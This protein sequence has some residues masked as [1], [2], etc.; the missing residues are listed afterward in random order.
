[1]E[2]KSQTAFEMHAIR[3]GSPQPTTSAEQL[4]R[5]AAI[6][7]AALTL[8]GCYRTG[9]AH[10]PQVYVTAVVAVLSDYPLDIVTAVTNP[11][12]GIPAK[13]KWLPTI[14]E[15]KTACEDI[16]GPRRRI[17]EWE[18][19]SRA[20]LAERERLTTPDDDAERSRVINGFGQLRAQLQ[21]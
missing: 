9:D 15:I 4:K 16:A 18:A 19:R 12:V 14:A 11:S 5:S 8:L 13:L 21:G 20:Q 10:D 2:E 6:K 7:N 3:Y 1:M 17:V